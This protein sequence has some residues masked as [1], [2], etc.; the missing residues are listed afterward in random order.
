[1]VELM[2][3]AAS[4]EYEVCGGRSSITSRLVPKQCKD[5]MPLTEMAELQM[6]QI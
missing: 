3:F 2:E 6:E 5:R 1:M 4:F